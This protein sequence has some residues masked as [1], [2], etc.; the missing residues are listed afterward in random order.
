MGS[1]SRLDHLVRSSI[2]LIR[3]SMT[4]YQ[5]LFR[6]DSYERTFYQMKDFWPMMDSADPIEGWSA[7]EVI[8]KAPLAKNDTYGSLFMYIQDIL[9]EFCYKIASLK[10]RFQLS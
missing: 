9:L 1:F 7:K 3:K 6:S 5:Q 4:L 8:Q 10:I 2:H